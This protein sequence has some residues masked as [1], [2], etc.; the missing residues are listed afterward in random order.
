MKGPSTSGQRSEGGGSL[1]SIMAELREDVDAL[2]E[3]GATARRE[4]K[5]LMIRVAN[6]ELQV[7]KLNKDAE[8]SSRLKRPGLPAHHRARRRRRC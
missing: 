4:L 5:E 7:S 8:R 3:D 1:A 6:L 2:E